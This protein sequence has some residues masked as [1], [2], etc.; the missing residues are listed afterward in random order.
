MCLAK[1]GCIAGTRPYRWLNE[2]SGQGA[3]VADK[4]LGSDQVRRSGSRRTEEALGIAERLPGI[5]ASLAT[6]AGFLL[7]LRSGDGL[8]L[9][10]G[11]GTVAFLLYAAWRRHWMAVRS[12]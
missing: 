12:E 9:L 7:S 10:C 1:P 4:T 3:G 2:L 6:V 11:L 5:A 8:W